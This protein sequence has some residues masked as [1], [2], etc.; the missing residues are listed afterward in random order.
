MKK[1]LLLLLALLLLSPAGSAG[2]SG[3]SFSDIEGHW[4]KEIIKDFAARGF[5]KGY[6][7]RTF[8]PDATITRAE[9]IALLTRVTKLPSRFE[10]GNYS[11]VSR[12]HW[13]AGAIREGYEK[14]FL[15]DEIGDR[16]EPDVPLTR[17][18]M[19]RWLVHGLLASD[20]SY[21]D[22]LKDTETVILPVTEY[23]RGG[24]REEDIP[25]YAVAMGTK[26]VSGFPD[27]SLGPDRT[28]TRAEVAVILSRYMGIEGTKAEQHKSLNEL[29]EVGTTGTNLVT[30]ANAKW[31]FDSYGELPFIEAFNV[32]LKTRNNIG[33]FILHHFIVIDR[34]FT[35]VYTDMFTPKYFQESI[36]N[37]PDG[38]FYL[39]YIDA[40]V[41]ANRDL[42]V[43]SYS[44][45]DKF[46]T[47]VG[48]HQEKID[49][50]GY[51]AISSTSRFVFEKDKQIRVWS[52]NQIRKGAYYNA[53]TVSGKSRG[54]MLP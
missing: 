25:Y 19:I 9:F 30:I 4:A 7:D 23:Y 46:L 43:S 47:G 34:E 49:Q 53:F 21:H 38:E 18:D 35:S 48:F 11:D 3:A 36:K 2:A 16:F 20:E 28:T 10:G 54:F 5:I 33:E 15:N 24:L 51:N 37:N 42:D 40:T 39:V 29:R 13:A 31:A 45:S 22:A 8:R 14:G 27:G 50:F 26:L 32:P 41:T 6:P 44:N 12:G 17:R 52:M 1:F